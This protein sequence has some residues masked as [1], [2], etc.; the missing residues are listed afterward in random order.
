MGSIRHEQMN[1]SCHKKPRIEP[2]LLQTRL[3][4]GQ[5]ALQPFTGV[6]D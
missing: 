1:I 4:A 5:A 2:Y 6:L 3:A